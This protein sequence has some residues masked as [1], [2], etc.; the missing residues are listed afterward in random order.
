MEWLIAIGL[1][2]L[3]GRYRW[4]SKAIKAL[5]GKSKPKLLK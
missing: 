1:A 2:Y 5:R 3:A 4:P